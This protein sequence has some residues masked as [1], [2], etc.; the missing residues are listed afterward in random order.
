MK[1]QQG[2]R[3]DD[4][5]HLDEDQPDEETHKRQFYQQLH[6]YTLIL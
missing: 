6:L 4:N 1:E 2:H 3:E 5:E